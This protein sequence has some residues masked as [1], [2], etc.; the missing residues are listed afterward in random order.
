[1]NEEERKASQERL[2]KEKRERQAA[3]KHERTRKEKIRGQ[4]TGD[5]ICL[6]CGK[7]I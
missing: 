3:C 7:F 1:M 5:L 2:E 6:D 4:D